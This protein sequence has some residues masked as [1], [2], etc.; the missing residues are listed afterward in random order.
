MVNE[1]SVIE[2]HG[3]EVTIS[4]SPADGTV[5]VEIDTPRIAENSEGPEVRVYLND[6]CLFENPPFP[7]TTKRPNYDSCDEGLQRAINAVSSHMLHEVW[8]AVFQVLDS[9]SERYMLTSEDAGRLAQLCVDAI[10]Y[11]LPECLAK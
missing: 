10:E 2:L 8:T 3:A 7:K 4:K 5:V 1:C 11:E 6:G 9:T